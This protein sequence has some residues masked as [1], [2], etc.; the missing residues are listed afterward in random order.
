MYQSESDYRLLPKFLKSK[1]AIL[2]PQNSDHRNFGYAIIY[3]LHPNDWKNNQ[4]NEHKHDR[5][6]QYG[7]D[8]I[9]YPVK[10]EEIPNLEDK[11]NIRIN[12]WSFLDTNNYIRNYL[13]I[14]DKIKKEEVNLLYWDGRF[15]LIKYISRFFSD[16]RK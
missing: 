2:N 8:E 1:Y 16:V 3:A 12:V 9:Q 15:A 4:F 13:Y 10:V 14:S 6:A 7:L 11:L 5:F